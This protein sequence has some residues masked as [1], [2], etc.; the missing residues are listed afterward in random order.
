MAMRKQT[1]GQ[2]INKNKSK[3]ISFL[4]FFLDFGG[5]GDLPEASWKKVAGRT[6]TDKKL[7]FGRPF[8]IILAPKCVF[9]CI[10]WV[11][12]FVLI[13]GIAF[14]KPPDPIWKDFGVIL[15]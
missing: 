14:R 1:L 9:L 12:G 11:T 7:V 2:K 5:S 4:L 13:F 10:F 3:S 6:P 15:D 8:W